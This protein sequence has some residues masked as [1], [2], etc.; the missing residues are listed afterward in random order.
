MKKVVIDGIQYGIR[1]D[2]VLVLGYAKGEFVSNV[3]IPATV[4]K[5]PVR[6][7]RQGAFQG[8]NIETIQIPTT[9]H[10][11]HKDAFLCCK[12]LTDVSDYFTNQVCGTV[13]PW[14]HIYDSAFAEC[15][16]LSK[17]SLRKDVGYLTDSAFAGCRNLCVLNANLGTIRKDVFR[18][19]SSL[20]EICFGRNGKICNHSIESSAIKKI[21]VRKELSYTQSILRHI[22]KNQIKISC[23]ANSKLLDL[24]YVGYAIEII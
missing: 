10:Y 14:L 3:I 15:E 20:T 23:P 24:A 21:T 22:R 5:K 8:T 1:D 18:D 13:Y 19:C 7:I 4:Q 11:I 9:I 2:E 6:Q 12:Q 16:N 17:V